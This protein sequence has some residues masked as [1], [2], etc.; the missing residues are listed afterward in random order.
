M[1]GETDPDN[2]PEEVAAAVTAVTEALGDADGLAA[3]TDFDGTLAPIVDRPDAARI[4]PAV[5]EELTV[6]RDH[7]ETVV[8]V[9]SGRALDDLRERVG[10]DGI[11]LAGNHGLELHAGDETV[12]NPDA[13][14]AKETID[15]V[16]QRLRE[17]IDIAGAVVENKGVTATI[18]YRMV[19]DSEV[20]LVRD[21]VQDAIAPTSLRLTEGKEVLE[22]RPDVEWDKGRAVEWLLDH[23]TPDGEGWTPVYVGDDTTDEAAFRALP[24]EGVGVKVGGEET[25]A[26]YRVR[27]VDDVRRF[28]EGVV[29]SPE[30]GDS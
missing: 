23:L 18:H 4:A 13:K 25:A 16:C 3:F 6:L 30:L 9:V 14:A 5:E 19:D 29:G 10:V 7:P 27:D 11:G 20:P 26:D 2:A 24:P 15:A 28:F 1:S 22:L 8:A 17:T 12:V 21:R